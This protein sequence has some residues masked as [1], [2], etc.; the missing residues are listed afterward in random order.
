MEVSKKV[1]SG[2]DAGG[3]VVAAIFGISAEEEAEGGGVVRAA[4]PEDLG[5]GEFVEVYAEFFSVRGHGGMWIW[6]VGAY[7]NADCRG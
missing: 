4:S 5:H 7:F 3:D 1:D 2:V 6:R